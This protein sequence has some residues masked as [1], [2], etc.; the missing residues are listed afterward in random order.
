MLGGGFILRVGDCDSTLASCI[1]YVLQI[2]EPA[3]VERNT[4][5]VTLD[6]QQG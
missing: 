3:L 4:W 2:Q 5:N 6:K 1:G